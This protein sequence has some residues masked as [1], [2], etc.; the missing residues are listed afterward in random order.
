MKTANKLIHGCW[1]HLTLLQAPEDVDDIIAKYNLNVA[2]ASALRKW[3]GKEVPEKLG[4]AFF[5][6]KWIIVVRSRSAGETLA[7]EMGHA[8]SFHE[9]GDKSEQGAHSA[10]KFFLAPYKRRKGF[11][12]FA[13]SYPE[14]ENG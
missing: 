10:A 8:W 2:W 3:F 9:N 13:E 6:A 12:R 1:W 4:I 11:H 7:H 14:S 5:D